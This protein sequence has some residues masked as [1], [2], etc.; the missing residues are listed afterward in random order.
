MEKMIFFFFKKI[1]SR[2]KENNRYVI[3]FKWEYRF[4][5]KLVTSK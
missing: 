3:L 5:N 4:K 2:H 1:I